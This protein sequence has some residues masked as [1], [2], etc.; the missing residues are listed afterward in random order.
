MFQKPATCNNCAL[1]QLGRGFTSPAGTGS[2]GVLLVGDTP[3]EQ[4][5]TL[6]YPFQQGG[7]TGAMLHR[8]LRLLGTDISQFA[9]FNAIACQ[10]PDKNVIGQPYEI[11]ALTHCAA[12]NL[13]ATYRYYNKPK[14]IVALGPASTRHLTGLSGERLS[15]DL[16]RGYALKGSQQHLNWMDQD[17][18]IIP[19]Y[20]SQYIQWGNKPMLLV[21]MRDL[22]FA[23]D[24]AALK[25]REAMQP[26]ALTGEERQFLSE[27]P[28]Y[29]PNY[30]THASSVELRQYYNWLR[31]N[32]STPLMYDFET[33]F[34][35]GKD[36]KTNMPITQ[37]N[38]S[39]GKRHAVVADYTS[40]T[41][42][43]LQDILSCTP[44]PKYA[45]NGY[46]FDNQ[47]ARVN[48]FEIRGSSLHDSM[49]AFHWLYS[50]IPSKGG[51]K[52]DTGIDASYLDDDGAFAALQFCASYYGFPIP[53][54][55]LYASDPHSY[56]AY[57]GDAVAW[58][59]EGVY[60]DLARF[61]MNQSYETFIVEMRLE[62]DA[63]ERRGIPG[64]VQHMLDF[65]DELKKH[66]S[67]KTAEIQAAVPADLR[68]F[69]IKKNTPKAV[70][71]FGKTFNPPIDVA[72]DSLMSPTKEW[73]P[74]E[75]DFYEKVHNL[76][77]T[78]PE[79]E[80][81]ISGYTLTTR[82]ALNEKCSC[83]TKRY[84]HESMA[85]VTCMLCNG[86]GHLSKASKS[87]AC[88]CRTKPVPDCEVCRGTGLH[89]KQNKNGTDS[90]KPC[91]CIKKAYPDCLSCEG[92]GKV[93]EYTKKPCKCLLRV[94]PDSM[95]KLCMGKGLFTG[96]KNAWAAILPFS[97]TS[98]K[99]MLEY[100]NRKGIRI[101][102][103][104]KRKV[105][106]DKETVTKL[107]KMTKDPVFLHAVSLREWQKIRSSY[108]LAWTKLLRDPSKPLPLTSPDGD[109]EPW[110]LKE[111]KHVPE[112]TPSM[113]AYHR[114]CSES[115]LG[116]IHTSFTFKPA[117]TQLASMN[118][119]VQV[120]PNT[121]KFGELA[122]RFRR[123]IIAPQGYKL[124]ELDYRA[125]HML[126]LGYEA[127]DADY[128]RLA[129]LDGHSF[130]AANLV[131]APGC[132]TCLSLPDTELKKY[133]KKIREEHKKT[134]DS[135]A[136]PAILGYGFGMGPKRL[137]D[138][139]P[140]S[141]ASFDEAHGVIKM[142]DAL[143]RR[144][145]AYRKE[146]PE[147]AFRQLYLENKFKCRRWFME[148]KAWNSEKGLWGHGEDWEASI[149]FRP[150]SNAFC[151]IKLAKLRLRQLGL[152]DKWNM[153]N[154]IHDAV[155]FCVPEHL[156]E[157]CLMKGREELQRP[158]TNILHPDGSPFWCEVEAKI[159]VDRDWCD[160]EEYSYPSGSFDPLS[161]EPYTFRA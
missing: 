47:V 103:N 57:D 17:T 46:L 159:S 111:E 23:M 144:A 34:T 102:M 45:H 107:A 1:Q 4:D 67:A 19:T 138:N 73:Q 105:C 37:V 29:R 27:R 26:G 44:N 52:K 75:R 95:C 124:V 129:R 24:V 88:H 109:I 77:K 38:L 13:S 153:I 82:E 90:T 106:M 30:K 62:L 65:A 12:N 14:V 141:F 126:T 155:L 54:K 156:V 130:L 128:I 80:I 97:V 115:H 50:D 74:H 89:T 49:W 157:E 28:N 21:L 117:S 48:G 76:S 6:G 133:L 137:F 91:K 87:V 127:G 84:A 86:T 121:T 104:S 3:G 152:A 5:V 116:L 92:K 149:A 40:E 135:K 132:D 145:S 101:P 93:K 53:W 150:A 22:K 55:H 79:G 120:T 39:S 134:R 146:S 99:Q 69:S 136:K 158:V 160:M 61:G 31:Q 32:P 108:A 41:I 100:T 139:N 25:G 142:L 63:M 35:K 125:F 98:P 85:V 161:M 70:V 64:S 81:K 18:L 147:L 42:A 143:F 114:A 113:L 96:S 8:A 15:L 154:N 148:A 11:Q 56:G 72:P 94:M 83:C 71:E 78:S 7:E 68:S 119:N 9:Q 112:K 16:L 66:M 36:V 131:G 123:G 60:G 2:N 122:K 118:P 110:R 58:V 10:P 151:V 33:L 20:S 51:P 140:E 43:I 59:M